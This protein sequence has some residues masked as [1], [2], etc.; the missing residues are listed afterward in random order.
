MDL[1]SFNPRHRASPIS[2]AF[3]TDLSNELCFKSSKVKLWSFGHTHYNC[4]FC[5]ERGENAGP[6]RLLANQR[7]YYFAQ[8]VGYDGERTVNV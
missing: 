3:S 1:R 5:V 8:A 4:D 2:S 7:G 6:L